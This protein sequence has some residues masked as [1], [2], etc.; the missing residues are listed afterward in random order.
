M[1]TIAEHI[2]GNQLV[3]NMV[4]SEI[5][6]GRTVKLLV[7]EKSEQTVLYSDGLGVIVSEKPI[8]SDFS[9]SKPIDEVDSVDNLPEW[10]MVEETKEEPQAELEIID[11][12]SDAERSEITI[13]F[14]SRNQAKWN[15]DIQKYG[16][17]LKNIDEVLT[18]IRYG[19]LY[20]GTP[21]SFKVNYK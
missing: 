21:N 11:N 12:V 1:K 4:R 9:F 10:N 3:A 17:G 13:A 6:R 20:D 19:Q 7:E 5:N 16:Y 15:H 8:G 18:H 14:N 2:N